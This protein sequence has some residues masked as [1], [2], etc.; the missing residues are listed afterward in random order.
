MSDINTTQHGGTRYHARPTAHNA[1][2]CAGCAARSPRLTGPEGDTLCAAMPPC[3]AAG[4]ADGANV[5]WV[6]EGTQEPK[7]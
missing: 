1:S 4:R 5:V 2:T 3:H 6:A 7:T